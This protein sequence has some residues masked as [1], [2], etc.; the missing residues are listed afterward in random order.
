[1]SDIMYIGNIKNKEEKMKKLL[2]YKELAEQLNMSSATLRI[3][4]MNKKVPYIKIGRLVRF[5]L[6]IIDEWLESKLTMGSVK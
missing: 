2:T 5:D 3:W 6:D 4:V 1:M